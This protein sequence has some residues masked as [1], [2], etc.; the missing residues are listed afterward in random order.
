[1]SV[2]H[3]L[4]IDQLSPELGGEPHLATW[5]TQ[6]HSDGLGDRLLMFDNTS[7]PSWEILRFKPA[8]ARDARFE[9]GLRGQMEQ[10]ASFH[11][12]AFPL[13]RPLNGLGHEDGLAVV[14]TY[15]AGLPLSEAIKRPRSAAFAVRLLHQLAPALSAFQQHAPGM[16]HGAL[17]ADHIVVTA[18]GRLTIR[19]HMVGAALAAL[20][21]SPENLWSDFRIV[22][23]PS[24]GGAGPVLDAR[25]DVIQLGLVVLSLMAGR[26]IGPDEYPDKI[27]GLLDELSERSGRHALVLFQS[28]RYWLERALQL[29]EYMFESAQDASDALSDLRDTADR[30]DDVASVGA[31]LPGMPDAAVALDGG[32]SWP[33]SRLRP[34]LVVATPTEADG[35]SSAPESVLAGAAAHQPSPAPRGR[36]AGVMRWAAI[37]VGVVAVGE[38]AFIGRLLLVRD[39]VGPPTAPPVAIDSTPIR[40]LP[41]VGVIPGDP[42]GSEAAAPVEAKGTTL[43]VGGAAALPTVSARNGGF[44]LV[45]PIEVHVIDN[46]RVLGS[47]TDGPIVAPAGRHEFEFVNSA[48]GYRMR[49]VVEIKPGQITPVS[50]PMPNGSLN[51]NAV[52]WAAVWIDGNSFGETPLGNL[53]IPAGEHE[54]VFRHPQLGERREKTMVRA[55]VATRVTVNLQR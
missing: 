34:Q 30:S 41:T 49:R 35:E 16:F 31:T 43:K 54:I 32:E 21:L 37:A 38:A 55:D 15:A 8:L 6:G 29:D 24:T 5:Y 36:I 44:R 33:S 10:L 3:D 22:A 47:S 42:R 1:M 20:G 19:E 45:S 4:I 53:S 48:I 2:S 13:V 27:E 7:A 11:H 28:L 9:A 46:E 17:D 23:S 18:N 14:S 39:V 50:V 40:L 12:P 25:T 26:R 51:V 52:P